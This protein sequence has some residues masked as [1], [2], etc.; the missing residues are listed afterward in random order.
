[1]IFASCSSLRQELNYNIIFATLL[2]QS[3][4]LTVQAFYSESHEIPAFD[5]IAILLRDC[6][7]PNGYDRAPG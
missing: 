7:L 2:Q 5:R 3:P 6:F 1:M 4:G